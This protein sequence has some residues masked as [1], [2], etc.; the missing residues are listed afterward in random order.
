VTSR[1]QSLDVPY[2]VKACALGFS[3]YLIGAH[4]WTWV[5]MF[6]VMFSGGADFRQLYV[7]GYTVRT[8]HASELYD[9][10]MQGRYQNAIVSPAKTTLP[11]NHLAY[12]SLLFAPFSA[13][14]YRAAYLAFLIINLGALLLCFLLLRP[15]LQNLGAVYTWLP[16]ALFLA[17]L[18]IGAALIQ[19][20]DSILLLTLLVSAFLCLE[21]GMP[22]IAGLLCGLGMFKFQIVLPIALLFA[23]WKRWRMVAG[24]GISSAAVTAISVW[25]VGIKG[26]HVYLSG[27]RR[28]SSELRPAE[29]ILY[30]ISPSNMPNIRGLAYAIFGSG[31]RAFWVTA[32]CSA[33]IVFLSGKWASRDKGGFLIA[34]VVSALVSYH[35]L[36][37]DMSVLA[38]PLFLTLDR[39]VEF[40]GTGQSEQLIF[41]SAAALLVTP[42]LISYSAEHFY[43]A[44]LPIAG[45]LAALT[46]HMWHVSNHRLRSAFGNGQA[47]PNTSANSLE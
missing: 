44:A 16:A 23:L 8:G 19:C 17:F 33:L 20:Q 7:A 10:Q 6:P 37:H 28:M 13:L 1:S 45:L 3:A 35:F 12:E 42:L 36:I 34:V 43:L 18:P 38:L 4:L 30:H 14:S 5:F 2:Y 24:F 39:T 41:R 46:A 27:L 11:F 32:A 31:H 29:Q 47:L 22:L 40:E 15:H 25:L 26:I 9:Y 21:S